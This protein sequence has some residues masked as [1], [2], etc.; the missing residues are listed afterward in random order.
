MNHTR[1]GG[2]RAFA[3]IAGFL[4]LDVKAVAT[5]GLGRLRALGGGG[6]V[7]LQPTRMAGREWGGGQAAPACGFCKG[8]EVTTHCGH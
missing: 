8:A 6:R 5:Y 3:G 4:R 1:A 2:R 7:H